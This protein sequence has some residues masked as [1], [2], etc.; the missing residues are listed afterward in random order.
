MNTGQDRAVAA[1]GVGLAAGYGLF[2]AAPVAR[3]STKAGAA[4]EQR[5][6][7]AEHG[8][9]VRDA[10]ADCNAGRPAQHWLKRTVDLVV[11][12]AGAVFYLPI[13][14]VAV[15]AV[16]LVDPGSVFYAQERRGHLGRPIKVWKLRTMYGDA[17]ARLERHLAS[18]PAARQEWRRCFKLRHDPRIL[19]WVGTFLRRSSVDELPQIWNLIRGEMTLVGPRPLPDYHLETFDREFRRLRHTVVPG[20]TGLWQVATRSDGDCAMMRRLDSYYVKNWSPS[21][22]LR[23]LLR[24]VAVVLTGRGAR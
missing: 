5:V 1:A 16:Q 20:L 9:A 23:I 17:A 11:A 14:A 2:G 19:P 21:L 10:A 7:L 8:R 12:L 22:D 15:L 13:V 18:D 4:S 6:R 24:T 3:R